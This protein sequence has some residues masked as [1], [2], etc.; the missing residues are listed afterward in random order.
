LGF[1]LLFFNIVGPLSILRSTVRGVDMFG[2]DS[3]LLTVGFVSFLICR[4]T[5][6]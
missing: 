3:M 6:P 2:L 5:T 4:I 1:V